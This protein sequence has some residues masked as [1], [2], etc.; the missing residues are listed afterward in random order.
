MSKL[1]V[2]EQLEFDVEIK[3]GELL[4]NQASLDVKREHIDKLRSVFIYQ[5]R[6][7]N[8]EICSIDRVEKRLTI[9]V[10]GNEYIVQLQNKFDLLLAQ[11]GMENT[12]SRKIQTV[13]APMPG[14][15]LDVF[16]NPNTPVEK[17]AKLLVLEAMK[18]ENIIKS[19]IDG[20]VKTVC[21]KS[22]DT[23]DKN[24]VLIVFE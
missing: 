3:H 21:I 7:F 1:I 12:D 5:N 2:N 13:I 9:K 18:M 11:L 10:N 8:T 20:I 24:V 15:V 4:L 14:L 16:V 23:V 17:G 6:V 19:P 22:G